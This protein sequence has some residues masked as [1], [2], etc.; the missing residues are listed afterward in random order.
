MKNRNHWMIL[1][2]AVLLTSFG[3]L[4]ACDA[5]TEEEELGAAETEIGETEIAEVGEVGATGLAGGGLWGD[6]G[7]WDADADAQLTEAEWGTGFENQVWDDWDANDDNRWGTDEAADTFWDAWDGNDDNIIDENEWNEGFGTWGFENAD[8][9]T[10]GDWDAEGD[11]TLTEDEFG[12]GFEE[13][14]WD[15]WDADGDGWVERDQVADTYWGWWDADDNAYLDE[16]EWG[17]GSSDWL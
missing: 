17:R 7:T 3:A 8:Y 9:G 1:M 11:G 14:G 2:L 15:D 12:T 10:F 4:A 6:Y 5:G 13:Y 16:N